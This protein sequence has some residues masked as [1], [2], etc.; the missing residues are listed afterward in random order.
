MVNNISNSSKVLFGLRNQCC[1]KRR[2]EFLTAIS[3]AF[4]EDYRAATKICC[5]KRSKEMQKNEKGSDVRQYEACILSEKKHDESRKKTQ[6]ECD[7][8]K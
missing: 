8:V 2:S 1:R 6:P 7:T 5:I 4:W 3:A